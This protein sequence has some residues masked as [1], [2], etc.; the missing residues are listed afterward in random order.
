[1]II[2]FTFDTLFPFCCTIRMSATLDWRGLR[3]Q[4]TEAL[5]KQGADAAGRGDR[6]GHSMRPDGVQSQRPD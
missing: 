3:P 6:L 5:P 2:D 1:M 4:I